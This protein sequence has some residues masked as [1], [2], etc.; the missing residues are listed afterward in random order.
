MPDQE[1]GQRVD[2]RLEELYR[3]HLSLHDDKVVSHYGPGIGYLKPE[4]IART[5]Q[6]PF[7][8]CPATTDG[9]VFHAGDH[10]PPFALQSISKVF[11]HGLVLEA[12]GRDRVLERVGVEPSG[13]A[14]NSVVFDERND[15]PHNPM[16]NAG[17]LAATALVEGA[18]GARAAGRPLGRVLGVLRRYAGN[19]GRRSLPRR[20]SRPSSAPC[21]PGTGGHTGTGCSRRT[22]RSGS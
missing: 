7:A 11:V 1:I 18:E 3:R 17:A 6:Q 4:Q 12:R 9:E 13:D 19:R 16:V 10:D 14:F 20:P 2:R 5:E 15:R 22:R 21:A 8:I